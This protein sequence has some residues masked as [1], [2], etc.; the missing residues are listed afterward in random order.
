MTRPLRLEFAGALYHVTSR[1]DHRSPIFLDELDRETWL[2]ILGTVCSRYNFV[3]H[4]YCQMTNH[5]HLL[6]ETVD[7]GLGTGLR[8]LN[9]AYS[10]H[11]NRRHRRIGHVFQGRYKAILCQKEKYL[12][13]LA[14][15][16]VLNPVRAGMVSSPA[17][18]HWSSY[19]YMCKDAGAPPWLEIEPL[20]LKFAPTRAE[21]LTAYRAFVLAGI[22]GQ[23]P[24]M[25]A[26]H[27]LFLGDDDF[28][29]QFTGPSPDNLMNV[30]RTH[31]KATAKPLTDYFGPGISRADGIADAFFSTAYSMAEIAT[32]CGI[33]VRT[34]SRAIRLREGAGT[35]AGAVQSSEMSDCRN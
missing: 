12:F 26:K 5:Y 33:S 14:R 19:Q 23:S 35:T 18:W 21:A 25:D 22:A 6:V 24:L 2:E 16:I 34:V 7:A 29:A 27:Q 28:I 20:L 32:H 11:F 15:Y 17:D 8:Q 4:S 13:E 31:R 1:G 3:V 30:S 10:Q 9:G